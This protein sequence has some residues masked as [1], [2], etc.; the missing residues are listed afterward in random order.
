MRQ[1]KP[2]F[3]AYLGNYLADSLRKGVRE[4][5]AVHYD[6]E[7]EADDLEDGDGYCVVEDAN[8]FFGIIHALR[9]GEFV[10]AAEHL[11]GMDTLPREYI[12]DEVYSWA[13]GGHSNMNGKGKNA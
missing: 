12:P 7:D 5:I 2:N 8:L 10:F 1:L 3:D 13:L 9:K 6:P 11:E 4:Y